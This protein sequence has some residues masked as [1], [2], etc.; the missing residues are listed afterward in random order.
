MDDF[1]VTYTPMKREPGK[2]GWRHIWFRC[3]NGKT[4]R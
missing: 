4:R 2:P 1:R 3:S